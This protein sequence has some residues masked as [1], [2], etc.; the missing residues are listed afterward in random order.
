M[1]NKPKQETVSP[2][3]IS[4]CSRLCVNI[5]P[6][7]LVARP[8]KAHTEQV[9]AICETLPLQT[10]VLARALAFFRMVRQTLVDPSE[11]GE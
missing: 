7:P 4:C 5:C 1:T 3:F 10:I 9:S 2:V 8:T 6:V 11:S